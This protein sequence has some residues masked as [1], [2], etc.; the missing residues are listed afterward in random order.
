MATHAETHRSSEAIQIHNEHYSP[1]N[2]DVKCDLL[3]MSHVLEHIPE[4]IDFLKKIR[5]SIL[6]PGG[7]IFLEVPNEPSIWVEQQIK[8][9]RQGLG[10]LNYFTPASLER[11]LRDA[12][13]A[14]PISRECGKLV[15][16]HMRDTQPQSAYWQR[17]WRKLRRIIPTP[18]T[19]PDYKSVGGL[20]PRIYLQ[21]I[22]FNPST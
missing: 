22:A 12:G 20:W 11:L 7:T 19:L 14:N 18:H 17:V 2:H 4:P 5:S 9:Q 6:N 13:Y 15:S 8:W 3:T 10:H 21:I 1:S 16:K